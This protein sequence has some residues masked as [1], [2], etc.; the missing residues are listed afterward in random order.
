MPEVVHL[1]VTTIAKGDGEGVTGSRTDEHGRVEIA[2]RTLSLGDG[3]DGLFEL[4]LRRQVGT[5]RQCGTQS[6]QQFVEVSI[7]EGRTLGFPLHPTRGNPK[8]LEVVGGRRAFHEPRHAGEHPAS[9]ALVAIRPEPGRP[10]NLSK[11]KGSTTA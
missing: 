7:I 10:S 6:L 3:A 1:E 11:L 9:Q 5:V 8:V 4:A 2:I